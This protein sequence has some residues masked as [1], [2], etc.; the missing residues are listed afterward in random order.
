MAALKY[1]F[2]W[3]HGGKTLFLPRSDE[4]AILVESQYAT[5][6]GQTAHLVCDFCVEQGMLEQS[7][8]KGG[9]KQVYVCRQCGHQYTRKDI[10]HRIMD[11]IV[12]LDAAREKFLEQETGT[13]IIVEEEVRVDMAGLLDAV[14]LFKSVYQLYSNADDYAIVLAKVHQYMQRDGITG[15][16]CSLG[17]RKE[18]RWGLLFPSANGVMLALFRDIRLLKDKLN[19]FVEANPSPLMETIAKYAVSRKADLQYEFIRKIR[20]GEEIPEE[21]PEAQVEAI[22]GEADWL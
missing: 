22:V 18:E 12:F 19:D 5:S 20:E 17:Y 2:K 4:K 13:D 11:G 14:P 15:L 3:V 10:R 8:E 21:E 1:G 16:I 7:Q 6:H 9:L